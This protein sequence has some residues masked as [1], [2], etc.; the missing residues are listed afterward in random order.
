MPYIPYSVYSVYRILYMPYISYTIFSTSQF[1]SFVHV[2]E[3][4]QGWGL[5]PDGSRQIRPPCGHAGLAGGRGGHGRLGCVLKGQCKGPDLGLVVE[6][7]RGLNAY[8]CIFIFIF[9]YVASVSTSPSVSVF[10]S[11]DQVAIQE[12]SWV[13]FGARSPSQ[14]RT[15]TGE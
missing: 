15:L 8:L 12:T 11:L 10:T 3:E 4:L 7:S 13:I 6:R 5:G 1:N 2:S 9:I 14:L